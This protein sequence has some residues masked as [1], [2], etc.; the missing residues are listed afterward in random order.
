[1]NHMGS[2]FRLLS[3]LC[4]VGLVVGCSIDK[5][6]DGDGEDISDRPAE[7]EHLRAEV[8]DTLPFNADYFTQGL[9]VDRRDGSLLVG[10]GGYGTS[11]IYRIDPETGEEINSAA[12]HDSLFGEGITQSAGGIWQLT[13]KDHIATLRNPKDLSVDHVA[14]PDGGE[15]WGVCELPTHPRRLNVDGTSPLPTPELVV[16]HGT[17]ELTFHDPKTMAGGGSVEVTYQ[18]SPVD[19]INELEC[20]GGDVYA[21]VW[22]STDILRI[23]PATGEVTAIIDASGLPNRAAN[24]PDNVLNGIAAIPETEDEDGVPEFYLTGKRWP[25]LYRVRLPPNE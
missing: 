18:G 12:M 7:P 23:D 17:S 4:L 16:S 3:C 11:G 5:H 8:T 25:D 15:G 20:V 1:M 2:R 19:K 14:H 13:W 10:T 9:E 24:D 6:S 22:M 21:N